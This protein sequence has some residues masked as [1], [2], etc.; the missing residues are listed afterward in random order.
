MPAELT[1]TVELVRKRH[2]LNAVSVETNPDDLQKE[3]VQH[4]R[5]AGVIR[6]SVGVQSFDDTGVGSLRDDMRH[7]ISEESTVLADFGKPQ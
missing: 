3:S 6:L 2:A 5:D 1:R 7:H 4:L